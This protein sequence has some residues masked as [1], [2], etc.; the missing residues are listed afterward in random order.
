MQKK[1]QTIYKHIVS[2]HGLTER[3]QQSDMLND[4][5][6]AMSEGK[7]ALLESATGTGKTLSL[8]L[9]AAAMIIENRK[10]GTSERVTIATP[11]KN[12]Q[13]QM[14]EE[15]NKYIATE[16][17][18]AGI[19]IALLKGRNN[20]IS[21]TEI[22]KLIE[23]HEEDEEAKSKVDSFVAYV[24]RMGGDIDLVENEDP[25]QIPDFV[26][27][28]SLALPI[29]AS[30]AKNEKY[31]E[32]SKKEA[33]DADIIVTNHHMLL[34]SILNPKSFIPK[35][36]IVIDEAHTFISNAYSFLKR[37]VAFR[38]TQFALDKML[39]GLEREPFH[40]SKK[41]AEDIKATH[42]QIGMLADKISNGIGKKISG[43]IF[44]I[45]QCGKMNPLWQ[46]V[47]M[48]RIVVHD[49]VAA[50]ETIKKAMDKHRRQY[51]DHTLNAYAKFNDICEA[52][53][54]FKNAYKD[55]ADRD[56]YY[57]ITFSDTLDYPSLAKV[58]PK[59][60]HI[61]YSGLWK[62][63]KSAVFVSGT[64][65]DIN[66]TYEPITKY[67]LLA[68]FWHVK[69][70]LGLNIKKDISFI[71]Y[72]YK[73]PF[74]WKNVRVFLYPDA[75]KFEIV[76]NGNGVNTAMRKALID[77][78]SERII[79]SITEGNPAI[80][81]GAMALMAAYEDLNMLA[82]K[83]KT[84]QKKRHIVA[85]SADITTSKCVARLK[86]APK[87]TMLIMVGGWEG[88]DFPGKQLTDL[89]IIRIPHAN[90]EDPQI[91]SRKMMTT[92]RFEEQADYKSLR[93]KD[94]SRH[95]RFAQKA[96]YLGIQTEDFW[97]FRQGLGRLVRHENDSGNIYIFD[98]RICNENNEYYIYIKRE[99]KNI[100]LR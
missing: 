32:Q 45:K 66:S 56:S 25:D 29:S 72:A 82:E 69:S 10:K 81:G 47:D 1:I 19:K 31:Y 50:L 14:I 51:G 87:K 5:Y 71:E 4:C 60:A 9:S 94:Y 34:Y 77:Y 96:S 26:D 30:S 100:E 86:R 8:L 16:K 62:H 6:K 38:S 92:K 75:P 95:M 57:V 59:I 35:D 12:L 20:Y 90:P 49:L 21:V 37:T 36:N 48:S 78:A 13:K 97:K 28:Q 58:T 83:L 23:E 54:Q 52:C 64:L 39:R 2:R 3:P 80:E 24:D 27:V 79:K 84:G 70:E 43:N 55:S 93:G 99:F 18:F 76:A 73:K 40:G 61:L 65:A 11:Q 88:V 42:A 68:S 33:A 67:R 15:F 7:I 44:Y 41:L 74:D 46:F 63:I 98:S 91:M 17:E 53:S 85:Q 22:E 89:F